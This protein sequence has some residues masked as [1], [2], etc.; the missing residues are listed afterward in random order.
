M[1]CASPLHEAK[2]IESGKRGGGI[3][4]VMVWRNNAI[5]SL[6]ILGVTYT[7]AGCYC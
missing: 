5:Y 1:Q 2:R 6:M 7:P 3:E 4:N